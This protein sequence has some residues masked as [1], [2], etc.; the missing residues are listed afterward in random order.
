MAEQLFARGLY[1]PAI[2]PPSVPPGQ[3]RLRISLSAAHDAA[4]I[5]RLVQALAEIAIEQSLGDARPTITAK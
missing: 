3:S 5:A 2:R 4:M 1:V